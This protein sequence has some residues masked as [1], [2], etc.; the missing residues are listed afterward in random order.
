MLL[1]IFA[2]RHIVG[3][4]YQYIHSHQ[5]GICEKSGVDTDLALFVAYYLF[6]YVIA[7]AGDAQTFAGLVLE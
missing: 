4:M 3:M 6:L 5:G 7:V 2:H 1:L